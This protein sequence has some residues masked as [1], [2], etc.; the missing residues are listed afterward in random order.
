MREEDADHSATEC[1]CFMCVRAGVYARTNH[2]RCIHTHAY[3]IA[4]LSRVFLRDTNRLIAFGEDISGGGG[5]D[6]MFLCG[7]I[8]A[9][10]RKGVLVCT[11]MSVRN[12]FAK[13]MAHTHANAHFIFAHTHTQTLTRV[14]TNTHV[15]ARDMRACTEGRRDANNN[16]HIACSCG[17]YIS[18]K[19]ARV[20]RD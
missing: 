17:T 4:E 19:C 11:C 8:S 15:H 13:W 18:G 10:R 16:L 7:M 3:S 1:V 14:R 12:I 9:F 6:G 2:S 20:S 5:G